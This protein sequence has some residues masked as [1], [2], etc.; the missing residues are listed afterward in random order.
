[1]VLK[2][3]ATH[4]QVQGTSLMI[5]SSP[6]HNHGELGFSNVLTNSSCKKPVHVIKH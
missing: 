3:T 4:N 6:I 1:M 5:H 2:I